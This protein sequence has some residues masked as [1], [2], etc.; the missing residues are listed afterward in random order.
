MSLLPFSVGLMVL[1]AKVPG[2]IWQLLG[3]SGPCS[4][5][6]ILAVSLVVKTI[7]CSAFGFLDSFRIS[8]TVS[9]TIS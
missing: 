9:G 1:C 6:L 5:G 3:S 2:Q 4:A 7:G 8:I